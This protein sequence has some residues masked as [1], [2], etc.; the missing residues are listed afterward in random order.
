MRWENKNPVDGKVLVIG[1]IIVCKRTVLIQLIVEDLVTF[2]WDKLYIVATRVSLLIACS[3]L[4]LQIPKI[5]I[6]MSAVM[7]FFRESFSLKDESV[8]LT[9]KTVLT[10]L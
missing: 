8:P 3:S 10:T 1:L 5:Q 6:R 9:V 2:L 7:Y 4:L